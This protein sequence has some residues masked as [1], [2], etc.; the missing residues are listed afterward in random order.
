MKTLVKYFNNFLEKFDFKLCEWSWYVSY[1]SNRK[2]K[3]VRN[4]KK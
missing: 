3:N 2:F 4:K 1:N